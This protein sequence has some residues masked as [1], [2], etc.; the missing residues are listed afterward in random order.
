MQ[1]IAKPSAMT[2]VEPIGK[3]SGGS[4][5]LNLPPIDET[6][7]CMDVDVDVDS[8][9]NG[10]WRVGSP[11]S[12]CRKKCM[13]DR[14]RGL[15]DKYVSCLQALDGA[16]D[17]RGFAGGGGPIIVHDPQPFESSSSSPSSD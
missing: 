4:P 7:P 5:E 11:E 17:M 12:P 14:I 8:K 3:P 2:L 15:A 10:E 9:E 1:P 13:K 16:G 6:Q